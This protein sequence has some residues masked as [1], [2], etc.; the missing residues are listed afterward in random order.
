MSVP[1]ARPAPG[2]TI[3]DPACGTGGFLMIA[4][5]YVSHHFELDRSQKKYLKLKALSGND[6]ERRVD[7]SDNYHAVS[8][9]YSQMAG[10]S[11]SPSLLASTTPT[12]APSMNRR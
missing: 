10:L 2:Q 1:V 9:E 3:H 6:A 4:H 5:D 11:V 7:V 12:G 8:V